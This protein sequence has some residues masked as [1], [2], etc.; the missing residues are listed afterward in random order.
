MKFGFLFFALAALQGCTYSHLAD[1]DKIFDIEVR[2]KD[3]PAVIVKVGSQQQQDLV[4]WIAGNRGGWDHYIV[5]QPSADIMIF[6]GQYSLYVAG[7][8]IFLGHQ[9]AT[10]LVKQL[11]ADEVRFFNELALLNER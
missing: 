1:I 5:T 9:D 7:S 8:A 2:A 10:M 3:Q 11:D 6:T 4:A